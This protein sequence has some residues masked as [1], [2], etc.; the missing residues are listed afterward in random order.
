MGSATSGSTIFGTGQNSF[1]TNSISPPKLSFGF[2]SATIFGSNQQQQPQQQPQQQTSI[3]GNIGAN[4]PT[5]GFGFGSTQSTFSSFGQTQPQ[6]Q[7]QQQSTGLS[8]NFGQQQQLQQPTQQF[9]QQNQPTG[10]LFD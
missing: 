3:F 4:N 10:L 6:P 7:P 2:G 1:Q 5:Q 8:L 9:G